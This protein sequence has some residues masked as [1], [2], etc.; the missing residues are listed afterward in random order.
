[1][2]YGTRTKLIYFE[3]AGFRDEKYKATDR[4]RQNGPYGT[5]ETK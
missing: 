5:I 1:M 3:C 4:F 2:G